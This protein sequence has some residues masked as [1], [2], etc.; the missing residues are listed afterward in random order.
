[1]NLFALEWRIR[2]DVY[3]NGG[4]IFYDDTLGATRFSDDW[5]QK[6]LKSYALTKH[7]RDQAAL[8]A[9]IFDVAP[10]LEIFPHRFNAQFEVAPSSASNAAILHFYASNIDDDPVTEVGRLVNELLKGAELQR[11]RI[12]AIVR[13]NHPWRRDSWIDDLAARRMLRKGKFSAADRLWF[14][15]RRARSLTRR[16]ARRLRR[17][18]INGDARK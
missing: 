5:H 11:S 2:R 4:V 3:V 13:H 10:R 1:M 14:Q 7:H 8:N 12:E 16:F 15:G 9:A 17:M 6:W 18:W